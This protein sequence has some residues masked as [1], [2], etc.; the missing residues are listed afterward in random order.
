MQAL[1]D[2]L[3]AGAALADYQHGPVER[4]GTTRALDG[5]EEREALADELLCPLQ[6]FPQ[7]R[8]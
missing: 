5:V 2:Q 6:H 1:G 7:P 4:R 3:L 8:N